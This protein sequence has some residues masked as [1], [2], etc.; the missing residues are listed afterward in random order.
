MAL[1]IIVNSA[2][3]G[4]SSIIR[5]TATDSNCC[6]NGDRVPAISYHSDGYLSIA[7]SVNNNGNYYFN[8]NIDLK[9]WYHVEIVQTKKDGKVKEYYRKNS[10]SEY[11]LLVL[12]YCQRQ[13]WCGKEC[14]QY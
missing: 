8:Y 5:F 1:D 11:L 10:H 12:L 7:S 2:G 9:K 6:N 3:E 13:W 14:G 4:W